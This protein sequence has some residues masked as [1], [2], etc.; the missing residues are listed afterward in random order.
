LKDAKVFV[1][2]YDNKDVTSIPL[3]PRWDEYNVIANEEMA[4][5]RNGETTVSVA[6]GNIKSRSATLLKG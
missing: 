3:M 4:K 2:A 6:L 5:V 1:D